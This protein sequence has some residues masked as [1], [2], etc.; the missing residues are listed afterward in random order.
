MGGSPMRVELAPGEKR[1]FE[2][3]HPNFV[4]RKVVV[5]GSQPEMI[6]GLHP[7][8]AGAASQPKAGEPAEGHP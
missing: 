7:K 8:A 5:D 3:G 1:A 6:V 4:T 2:V